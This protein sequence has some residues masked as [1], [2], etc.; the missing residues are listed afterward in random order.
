MKY[1]SFA[2][3]V[4]WSQGEILLSHGQAAD[5]DHPLVLERPDLF[6]GIAPGAS[7]AT[8]PN[9]APIERATHAPGETRQTR[10]PKNTSGQ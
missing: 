4:A 5:D 6:Q 9:P 10:V 3:V 1:S 8:S 7:L 2:G